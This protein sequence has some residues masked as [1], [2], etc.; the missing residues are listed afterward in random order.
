[1]CRIN[2]IARGI[3]RFICNLKARTLVKSPKVRDSTI[4]YSVMPKPVIR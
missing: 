3:S 4:L 1:M 2:R